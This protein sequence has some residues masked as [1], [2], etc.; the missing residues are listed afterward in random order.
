METI[1]NDHDISIR[2]LHWRH[3]AA[4]FKITNLLK[5]TA[6][7]SKL[8][9]PSWTL[10]VIFV[11]ITMSIGWI[12]FIAITRV[13]LPLFMLIWGIMFVFIIHKIQL[14]S[15]LDAV[16][17]NN[18]WWRHQLVSQACGFRLLAREKPAWFPTDE[19]RSNFC[20]LVDNSYIIAWLFPQILIYMHILKHI[21]SSW[22]SKNYCFVWKPSVATEFRHVSM[23][24][25]LKITIV[26]K[27]SS[28]LRRKF[29][30]TTLF[31]HPLP[32]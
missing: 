11:L 3:A 17:Y 28:E 14:C 23:F 9:W 12:P 19:L 6:S 25:A 26:Q 4:I 10:I 2:N 20:T 21:S 27:Q 24:S 18:I 5:E 15:V 1:E 32:T 16:S 29:W 31:A 30:H 8:E 7:A 13:S 22:L